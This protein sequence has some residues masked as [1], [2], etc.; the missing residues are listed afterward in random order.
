[1]NMEVE[2]WI[3]SIP[4]GPGQPALGQGGGGGG[5]VGA[6]GAGRRSRAPQSGKQLHSLRDHPYHFV[7]LL[8]GGWGTRLSC[9]GCRHVWQGDQNT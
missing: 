9:P 6:G 5:G 2:D 3:T 7:P 1:M 4:Q 8:G